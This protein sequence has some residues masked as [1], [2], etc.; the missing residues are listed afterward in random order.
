VPSMEMVAGRLG[1]E[2]RQRGSVSEVLLLEAVAF[3]CVVA[4]TWE[5]GRRCR[6]AVAV[7]VVCAEGVPA[8]KVKPESD[9][10][11]SGREGSL[12]NQSS[13]S[14]PVDLGLVF[15]D[16][17][18]LFVDVASSSE[19]LGVMYADVGQLGLAPGDTGILSDDLEC[20]WADLGARSIG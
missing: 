6:V 11:V 13:R 19:D 7:V 14:G 20:S 12:V 3:E 15:V 17:G 16:S 8:S 5:A 18:L 10:P 4:G 1:R 2:R 9:F